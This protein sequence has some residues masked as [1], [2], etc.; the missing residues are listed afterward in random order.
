MVNQQMIL[1]VYHWCMGK[2]FSEICNMTDI[3][4]GTIVRIMLRLIE[5]LLEIQK[6]AVI[7]GNHKLEKKMEECIVLVKR[8]IVYT[9]SLYI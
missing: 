4:E 5:C 9:E 1:I 7:I 2:H 3:M 8:D 6:I